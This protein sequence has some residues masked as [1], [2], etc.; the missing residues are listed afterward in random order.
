MRVLIY[1]FGNPGR[2][3]DG[4]GIELAR[5]IEERA[6]DIPGLNI[7]VESDCQLNVEDALAVSEADVVVFCDAAEEGWEPFDFNEVF[8]SMDIAF[9]T[10]SMAPASLLALCEELYGKRPKAYLLA[11][12]GYEWEIKEGLSE[13]AARTLA[14]S[15]GFLR[16]FLA[17]LAKP[18]ETE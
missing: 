10:H 3:D 15:I 13:R 6:G 16:G 14:S 11:I 1:G 17:G 5:A 9:T 12:R 8:P 7:R 18:A 4:I 2:G